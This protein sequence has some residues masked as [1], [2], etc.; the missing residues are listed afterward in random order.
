MLQTLFRIASGLP[1]SWFHAMG[2]FL[3]RIVYRLSPRYAARLGEN[4]RM[5]GIASDEKEYARLLESSVKEAGKSVLELIPVWFDSEI[6]KKVVCDDWHV[7]EEVSSAGRGIIFLTPHLGCFEVSAHYTSQFLPITVLYRRPK[8]SWVEPFML[9]GRKYANLAPAD[10][11]GVR[12]LLRALKKGETVGLLPDQAPGAGE[13]EWAD[14]FGRPAYTMTLV[15]KL[16]KATGATVIMAFA[17]RLPKGKG[18][19][20]HLEALPEKEITPAE[21]NRQIEKMVKKSPEQYLWS[22]N[23]YKVPAGA[24][25]KEESC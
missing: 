4:L 13:G 19:R 12:R 18:Y 5:S 2:S 6:T 25:P 20:L 24:K 9:S 1:L 15:G 8:L 10:L 17:E 21:L 16:Q 7:A 23:R 14:F 3:G 11:S 22:Y